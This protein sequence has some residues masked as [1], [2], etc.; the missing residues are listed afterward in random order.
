MHFDFAGSHIIERLDMSDRFVTDTECALRTKNIEQ[1]LERIEATVNTVA[2]DLKGF[3]EVLNP[4]L[5]TVKQKLEN[6]I[7]QNQ[8]EKERRKG[9]WTPLQV[10]ITA[11]TALAAIGMFIVTLV[12]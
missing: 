1:S 11:I 12:K 7:G 5:S 3:K 6:H 10:A 4:T 8:R 9:R 2:D